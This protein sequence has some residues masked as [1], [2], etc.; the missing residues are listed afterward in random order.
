MADPFLDLNIKKIDFISGFIKLMFKYHSNT[1]MPETAGMVAYKVVFLNHETLL[2]ESQLF[3]D[4]NLEFNSNGDSFISTKDI[5]AETFGVKI[6][7][8]EL[9]RVLKLIGCASVRKTVDGVK[10]RGFKNIS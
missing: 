9:A 10:G 3:V 5:L 4:E 6:S 1:P 2:S 8:R 7:A